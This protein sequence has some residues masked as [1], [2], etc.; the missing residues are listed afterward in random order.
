MSEQYSN[1]RDTPLR[2]F[3]AFWWGLGCFGIFG[4]MSVIVYCATD[5]SADAEDL[6]K[7]DRL[8]IRNKVDNDQS[9][10]L[11][12]KNVSAVATKVVTPPTA[13][14]TF[15]PGSEAH[16]NAM[17]ALSAKT[18]GGPGFDL[19]TKKTCNTCH[20]ADAKTPLAPNYPKLAGQ[21]ADYLIAQMKDF[22]TSKRTNGQSAIM[23]ATIMAQQV[24]DEDTKKISDWLSK[25]DAPKVVLADGPG[26]NLYTAKLCA[27]CHGADGNTP[28]MPL[29]P[30]I[31]GQ[32]AQYLIDQM[33]AIKNGTRNNGQS[34]AMMGIMANVS[35]DEIK[36]LAEWLSGGK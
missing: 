11:E 13:T 8:V 22:A 12:S 30:K 5:K 31:A 7:A 6:R 21:N 34:A 17:A 9:K 3:N 20:G 28:I 16:K 26:K 32:N 33:K 4:L 18:G 14:E 1:Y 25:L 24:T 19:Y 15:V 2:R 27:T 36:T 29:Y 35:E 23:T 10:I